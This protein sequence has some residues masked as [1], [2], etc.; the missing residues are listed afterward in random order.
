MKKH[1]L[2]LLLVF[3]NIISS[4]LHAQVNRLWDY[5]YNPANNYESSGKCIAVLPSGKS[6]CGGIF[7]NSSNFNTRNI[8][9]FMDDTGALLDVDST[10]YGSGYSKV[11]YDGKSHFIAAGTLIN[12]SLP[13]NK[14]V[15]ARIDTN[16]ADRQFLIP[17]SSTVSPGYDVLDL[18]LLSN[19]NMVVAS[20][21][22]AFPIVSLSLMC[23]DTSGFVLWERVDSSFQFSYDVKL[24]ADGNG[25]VYAAGSGKDTSTTDDFIFVT[26]YT[27]GGQ[28]DWM[29]QYYSPA[30]FFADLTDLIPDA[31]GH[32]YASGTVM[33][34]AG[35]LG[36]LMKLDTTGT[37]VW[38]KAV[39][40]LSYSRVIT[41]PSGNLY[42]VKVP[43]DG[44]NA[45]TIDKMD[46]SATIIDSA[47]FHTTGYFASELGDVAIN[48]DGI[49]TLCGGLFV[50]SFPKS[51]LFLAAYDTSLNL[52]GFDIYDSLNLLGENA[53]ALVCGSQGSVYV[54]G[55]TNFENQFE[56]STIGILKY[57]LPQIINTISFLPGEEILLY[58]NPSSGNINLRINNPQKEKAS[59]RIYNNSGM[60][61]YQTNIL[62][63]SDE[64]HFQTDLAEGFYTGVLEWSGGRRVFKMCI[65]N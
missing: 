43:L 22:D 45:F 21:W 58:P 5:A 33:D 14:I 11:I 50:L 54:C 10:V 38:N 61:V 52:L 34:S 44:I 56:T 53:K 4:N 24:L 18:S 20:H 57:E 37:V 23:M 26:H 49:I 2:S 16:F 9:V 25:G 41:D 19:T 27:S 46:S 3:M 7:R 29:I 35:Q 63:S 65:V 8:L 36:F 1:L 42:G 40:P 13:I 59:V 55:R 62:A 48:S 39:S 15:L 17:D 32:L 28:R 12:D 47:F 64:L 6:L 31:A 60:E 51:D 30:H